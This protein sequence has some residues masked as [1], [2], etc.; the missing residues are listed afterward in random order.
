MTGNNFRLPIAPLVVRMFADSHWRKIMRWITAAIV[1]VMICPALC[2]AQALADRIPGD[3]ILYIGWQGTD[4]PGAGYDGSHLQALLD[5]SQMRQFLS[6]SLPKLIDHVAAQDH[7]A[8]DAMRSAM[9]LSGLLLRHPTA[10]YF[11][12]MEMTGPQ[13]MP[14]VA[15]LCDA[16]A[17]SATLTQQINDLLAKAGPDV[18]FKCTT[19]GTLVVVSISPMAEHPDNPLSANKDFT[20]AMSQVGQQPVGA[21]YLNGTA[22]WAFVDQMMQMAPPE[23]QQHWPKIRDALGLAGVKSIA[24]SSGFDGKNW[25]SQLMI[26][27]PQ[28]RS[29]ALAAMA[30]EPL[31]DELMALIPQSSTVAG[32]GTFDLAGLVTGVLNAVGQF[33]PPDVNAQVQ[34]GIAQANQMLGLDIQKDFF[35]AFGTQWVYYC[36]PTAMGNGPLG[37]TIVNRPKDAQ[38]LQAS[39]EKIEGFANAILQQQLRQAHVTVAFRQTTVNNASVHYLATPLISPAWAIKDG[40]WYFGLY[41]DVVAAAMKRQAGGPSIKENPAY[42][43]VMKELNGPDKFQSFSFADLPKTVPLQYQALIM[44]SRLYGGLGD[45]A[46]M[47]TPA[48]LLPPLDVLQAQTEPAGAIAWT[49]HA[50]F[51]AK[52]ISPFP[53]AEGLAA[54]QSLSPA[55]VGTVAMTTAILLPSLNRARSSANRVASMSNLRQIGTGCLMYASNNQGAFPPD[56]GTLVNG[57]NLA[58]AVFINPSGSTK[59]PDMTGM[60]PDDIAKWVNDNSD[61]TYVAAGIK[62]ADPNMALTVIAYEKSDNHGEGKNILFGDGHIEFQRLAQARQT[63]ENTANANGGR[64]AGG[65]L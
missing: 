53:G 9:D 29:G 59:L 30:T 39:M 49:D 45:L 31:S 1:S 37:M 14:K 52:S 64:T 6:E 13:P 60:S 61:Y 25:S 5:A 36:D 56:L 44:V 48:M 63:I 18:P 32:G 8:A 34:Q 17:D 33:A 16:G 41:P 38:Q 57:E 47:E 28:P 15:L 58:A 23:A 42:Q 27:A 7:D 50:G 46:G 22:A 3:A 10:L 65:G 51:H 12:G 11:G 35:G 55:T 4:A 62:V 24:A 2:L 43:Q 19:A 40:T 54:G 26:A 20:T 21:F